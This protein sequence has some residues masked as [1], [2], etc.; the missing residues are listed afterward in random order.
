MSH[1]IV[2]SITRNTS[3][4]MVSQTITWISSFILML[5]L[6]RYLGTE[7][8]G[9][10][11]LA[12]SLSMI[13][14]AVIEFGGPFLVAK[15][16]A[17]GSEKAASMLSNS[18]V[19][20]A[21]LW[22]I[23]TISIVAISFILGYS[24]EVKYLIFIL[25][26]S[27]LWE[28][29]GRV[30]TSCFQGFEMMQYPSLGAIVERVFVAA[31]GVYALFSGAHAVLIACIM[32][33]S[34]FLNFGLQ[35]VFVRRIIP[36]IPRYEWSQVRY[37]LKAGVPYFLWSMCAIIY[38]RVDAVMLSIMAPERVVGWY[39]AAY[40]VFDILMFLPSI[41][42][43]AL[44]PVLSKSWGKDNH[45]LA[46]T[47]QKSVDY[48][49]LAGIPVSVLIFAFS[50]DIV[51]ILFGLQDYTPSVILLQI[52]A[53]GLLL[54][55]IDF[56]I[57]SAII[58][59]EKTKQW[60]IA[61]FLAMLLNP[62]LNF[63]LIPYTEQHMGNGGIGSALATHI[64]EFAVMCMALYL[65]PREV[66]QNSKVGI[67]VKGLAAGAMM[68][69]SL[70]FLNRGNM[71]F[72]LVAA[73]GFVVYLVSLFLLKGFPMSDFAVLKEAWSSKHSSK[74]IPAEQGVAP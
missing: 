40:R 64:T 52:F 41:Y 35:T 12:I 29:S 65:V 20:R 49:L 2:R 69:L 46:V 53:V 5:V 30:I 37:L 73:I 24:T 56:I 13:S 21:V 51:R 42:S 43:T 32:A 34:T 67:Q 36:R 58:A 27:K 44:F 22:L 50:S 66:F 61:A 62:I 10:L 38:Y 23:S 72:I 28:G 31:L 14:Q 71:N 55:Y 6:P 18:L 7:D 54:V 68:M 48:I 9:R 63:L 8:Y 57:V 17:R 3:V 39:G 59:S 33:L 1:E 19:L 4:M 25:G 11:Y 47:T 70:Y 74:A 26:V 15:E 60:T 45:V 16:I